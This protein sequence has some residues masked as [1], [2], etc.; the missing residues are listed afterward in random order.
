[1]KKIILAILT[2]LTLKVSAQSFNYSLW[3]INR[4]CLTTVTV[5]LTD[6]IS[7]G[8]KWMPANT[9]SDTGRI[10]IKSPIGTLVQIWKGTLSQLQALPKYKYNC[11]PDSLYSIKFTLPQGWPT[12]QTTIL[13]LY[14]GYLNVVSTN[15]IASYNNQL[16]PI[17]EDFYD[18]NGNQISELKEGFNI[19]ITTY[20]NGEKKITKVIKTN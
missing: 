1:M 10:Y 17:S 15:G 3:D 6:T 5:N 13:N 14:N 7:I 8:G 20:S 9:T 4:T 16:K 2:I 18:L 12:G 19:K 11:S